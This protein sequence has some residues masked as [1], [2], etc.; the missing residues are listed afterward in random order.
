[1]QRKNIALFIIC[2]VLFMSFSCKSNS[3]TK[4]SNKD[5][6]SV[7]NQKSMQ[8]EKYPL[9]LSFYSIGTGV[10][11]NHLRKFSEFL[12]SYQPKLNPI[13]TPW[14]GEGEVDFCFTLSELSTKQQNQ[15]VKQVREQ[16]KDCKLVHINENAPCVHKR[17]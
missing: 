9:V 1:M 16:L 7:D 14:G 17:E 10:D 12:E 4:A 6:Q 11:G 8:E 3:L 13:I 15:F 2:S 5:K